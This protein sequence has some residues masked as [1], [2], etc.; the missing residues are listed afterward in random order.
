VSYCPCSWANVWIALRWYPILLLTYSTGLGAIAANNYE[1]L[2]GY[3]H[4]RVTDPSNSSLET[5]LIQALYYSIG[6]IHGAFKSLPGHERQFFPVSEYL[7]K[8]FQPLLDDLLFLGNDYESI[9]DRLEILIALEHAYERVKGGHML[10]GPI[11]R[12]GWKSGRGSEYSPLHNLIAEAKQSGNSWAPIKA[13]MFDGSF[14][15]FE[16]I[17]SDLL[18]QISQRSWF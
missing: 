8:F 2:Y 5:S 7:H 15:N 14:E 6:D 3:F 11:G 17:S 12:F 4:S 16:K 9:F 10:W 18:G 1:N 13:G